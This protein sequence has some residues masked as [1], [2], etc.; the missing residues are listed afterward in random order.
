MIRYIL[1]AS[2]ILLFFNVAMGQTRCD[3][4]QEEIFMVLEVRPEPSVSIAQL[5]EFLNSS[6]DL[7]EY[8]VEDGVVFYINFIVNCHGE[9]F[10]YKVL[11]PVDE[12]LE[13]EILSVLQSHVTWSPG[14]QRDKEVDVLKIMQIRV[15]KGSLQI[16]EEKGKKSRRR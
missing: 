4:I 8:A 3:T 12:K 1:V 13:S 14:K 5:E 16:V 7:S 2:C 6:I 11:K 9:H 15:E 10:D